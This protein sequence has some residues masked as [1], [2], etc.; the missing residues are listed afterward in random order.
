MGT[1]NVNFPDKLE[2]EI[3]R[4]IEETGLFVNRSELVRDAVRHRLEQRAPL[5]VEMREGL[6]E[7]ERQ[8]ERGEYLSS[9]EAREK[10]LE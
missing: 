5:S 4:Y 2:E 9:D 10:Y 8:I 3:D 6:R 1:V 7:S